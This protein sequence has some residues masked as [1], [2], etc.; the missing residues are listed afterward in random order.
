MLSISIALPGQD[1]NGM[2]GAQS[3]IL[4]LLLHYV[5]CIACQ[6]SWVH[7]VA[8]DSHAFKRANCQKLEAR[9]LPGPAL[10]SGQVLLVALHAQAAY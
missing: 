2:L 8:V 7:K 9:C 4:H 10:L 5:W 6:K 1:T 3:T